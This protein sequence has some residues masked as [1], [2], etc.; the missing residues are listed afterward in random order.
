MAD[1]LRDRW[2]A[3][4]ENWVYVVR[5][6]W[7][8]TDPDDDFNFPSFLRILPPPGGKAL[9]V[10]CGEG[11]IAQALRAGGYD[12]EGVDASPTMIAAA[13]RGDPGGRYTVADAAN[14]P[15]DDASFD[16]VVAF[17]S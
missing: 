6:R 7:R 15:F 9:E 3:E 8:S 11:R 12:I 17:M 10:G 5:T 13:M 1:T 16:L 2:E 4:A 14:L